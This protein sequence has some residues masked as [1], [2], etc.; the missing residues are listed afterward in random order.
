MI[1]PTRRKVLIVDDEPDIHAITRLSLRDLVHGQEPV[2]FLS[3]MSGRECVERLR[4][5]PDIGVVLLDVVMEEEHA[6]LDSIGAIREQLGNRFV[7]ILL[8]TGQ[9]GA[10]PER[11]TIERYDIDGY[12]P[13]GEESVDRVFVAVRTALRAWDQLVELDR[14]RR[15]LEI[16]HE[17]ALSL[18]A[19]DAVDDLLGRILDAAVA[20]CPAPLAVLSLQTVSSGDET[21][22]LSCHVSTQDD[23]SAVEAKV[24]E[25]ARL[26][27]E[28]LN[29][30]GPMAGGY[31][32]PIALDR[33][34][35]DGWLYVQAADPDQI[36]RTH[37][38]LLVAHARNALYASV[39]QA[40]LA[41][42]EGPLFTSIAV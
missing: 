33:Q 25:V 21:R 18:H 3:A 22:A 24:E 14:R 13:K 28:G 26:L 6:G 2:E 37:L 17:C 5:Q 30:E 11:E 12:L 19:F 40:M 20:I 31:M 23:P 39:A 1:V 36:S 9:P 42:R 38:S 8:R 34:L 7:R 35:G 4:E 10:A 27:R 32:W 16:V 29:Q 41:G 15:Q